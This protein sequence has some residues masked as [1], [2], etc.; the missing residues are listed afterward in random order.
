MHS[1][2]KYYI[3]PSFHKT[4]PGNL[5]G[6]DTELDC[7]ISKEDTTKFFYLTFYSDYSERICWIHKA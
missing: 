6:Y 3:L 4:F 5:N 7:L 1:E 2:V